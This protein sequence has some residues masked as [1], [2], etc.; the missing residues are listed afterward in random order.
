MDAPYRHIAC[1]VDESPASD[2]GVAEA[3]RLRAV[4]PGRLSLVHVFK[5]PTLY[6]GPWSPDFGGLRDS[7]EQWLTEKASALPGAEAVLLE[8]IPGTETVAWAQTAGVDLLVTTT[9]HGTGAPGG[10]RQLHPPPAAPRPVPGAGD[11]RRGG[12]GL[13]AEA[14]PVYQPAGGGSCRRCPGSA[15]DVP[16]SASRSPRP[17]SR[18]A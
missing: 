5:Y 9:H 18:R 15:H 14:V 13:T 6:G 17:P 11:P 3:A 1:C 2:A 10:A 16:G 8:G 12:R 4:G 7:A